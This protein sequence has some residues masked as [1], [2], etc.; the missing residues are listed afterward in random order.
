MGGKGSGG[1][2]PG[3]GR[4]P[5]SAEERRLA[6]NAGHR[7][8]VLAHPSVPATSV[9]APIA[10]IPAPLPVVDEADAPNDLD[11]DERRVW[12]ELAPLAMAQGT[13]T[14][15]KSFAFRLLCRNIVL[16]RRYASSVTDAGGASHRGMIQALDR[17]LLRFGLS[18]CGKPEVAG[19]QVPAVDPMEA[20]YFG[21]A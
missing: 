7:G 10:T 13:L 5:K 18:P 9:A 16:E 12:M 3:A 4:K 6:G 19:E 21:R 11:M 14:P 8:R 15:S 2:R 20:K 17:E 1:N